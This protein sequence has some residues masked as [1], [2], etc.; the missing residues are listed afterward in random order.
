MPKLLDPEKLQKNKERI[1]Q[2]FHVLERGEVVSSKIPCSKCS[3][4]FL[5]FGEFSVHRIQCHDKKP[6][7][8]LDEFDDDAGYIPDFGSPLLKLENELKVYDCPIVEPILPRRKKKR[9]TAEELNF[10]TL[11]PT[12][13]KIF[14]KP[15][16]LKE[17]MSEHDNTQR[18][19]DFCGYKTAYRSRLWIHMRLHHMSK[20]VCD[21][22]GKAIPQGTQKKH[23]LTHTNPKVYKCKQCSALF[24]ERKTLLEHAKAVHGVKFIRVKREDAPPI[25]RIWCDICEKAY[26]K[27]YA[28]EH[29]CIPKHLQKPKKNRRRKKKDYDAAV[30]KQENE[31]VECITVP[32]DFSLYTS[33]SYNNTEVSL[34]SY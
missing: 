11:C 8:V 15:Y 2:L 23:M 24:S 30:V 4:Q 16:L 3:R 19:C 22:C 20:M 13:G 34:N 10:N 7:L 14:K 28:K 17:H 26:N 25:E 32:Q 33:P 27:Y 18:I 1:S 21:I 29:K 6:A 5:R 12:C 9:R 31:V